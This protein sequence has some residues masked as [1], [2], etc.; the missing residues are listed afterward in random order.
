MKVGFQVIQKVQVGDRWVWLC[1]GKEEWATYLSINE[2]DREFGHYYW[3][4]EQA[5]ADFQERV[6]SYR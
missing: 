1:G 2:T 5:I 4:F 3:S 6:K